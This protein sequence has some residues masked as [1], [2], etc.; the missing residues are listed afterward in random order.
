V[1][2][3]Q[4]HRSFLIPVAN[5][6]S[7]MSLWKTILMNVSVG[8]PNPTALAKRGS[9]SA[10]SGSRRTLPYLIGDP[11]LTLVCPVDR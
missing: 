2:S 11:P 10:G 3:Y 5:N 6:I 8:N 7:A 1:L 4:N 9:L